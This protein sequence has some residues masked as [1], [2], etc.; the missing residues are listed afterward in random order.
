MVSSNRWDADGRTIYDLIR[1]HN[2]NEAVTLGQMKDTTNKKIDMD[3]L[4]H[5]TLQSRLFIL[6]YCSRDN[7]HKYVVEK[8]YVDGK[9][10]TLDAS[11]GFDM[12]GNKVSK[13]A[14]SASAT[15]GSNKRYVDTIKNW[16]YKS[17]DW[18]FEYEE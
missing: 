13:V 5:Q 16:W 7:S 8:K 15:N 17:D 3:N 14:D 18:L 11:K 2:D 10:F 9:T 4:W 1:A 12:K 6:D